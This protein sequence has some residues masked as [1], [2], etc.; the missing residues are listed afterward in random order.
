MDVCVLSLAELGRFENW[1]LLPACKHHYHIPTVEAIQG[2]RDDTYRAVDGLPFAVIECSSNGRV[3]SK[4][5]SQGFMVRQLVDG[6]AQ[7]L[8]AQEVAEATNG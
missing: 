7:Y 1:S 5:S 6:H 3:W 2:V 4:K 8:S